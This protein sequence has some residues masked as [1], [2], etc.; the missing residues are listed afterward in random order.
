M[1]IETVSV[2]RTLPRHEK[3]SWPILVKLGPGFTEWQGE[4]IGGLFSRHSRENR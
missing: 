2:T 3:R 1:G 4:S